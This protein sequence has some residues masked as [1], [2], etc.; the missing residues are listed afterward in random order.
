[1]LAKFL[2]LEHDYGTRFLKMNFMKYGL[3]LSQKRFHAALFHVWFL[4]VRLSYLY[5]QIGF[6]TY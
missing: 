4:S 6:I 1:M 5:I 2:Y 3:F